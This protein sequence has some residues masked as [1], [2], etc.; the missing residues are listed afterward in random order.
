MVPKFGK[1]RLHM[2][3]NLLWG[4]EEVTVGLTLPWLE[5]ADQGQRKRVMNQVSSAVL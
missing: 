5:P 1:R 2:L 4:A 3:G